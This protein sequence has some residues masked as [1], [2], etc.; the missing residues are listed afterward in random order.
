MQGL[1]DA[2]K[3]IND[4]MPDRRSAFVLETGASKSSGIKLAGET[5]EDWI[6]E[7]HRAS[8]TAKGQSKI[9]WATAVNLKIPAFDPNN[10]A[11][12][13]S[14]LYQRMYQDDPEQGYAYLED[15]MAKAEPSYGY[16]V[17]GRIMA[18]TRHRVVIT[19]NFDNLVADPSGFLV[20][21]IRWYADMNR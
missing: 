10:P 16:S 8:A 7:L 4:T 18:D 15:Q 20:P 17:L 21:A 19:V 2:F 1:I 5:V 6:G 9:N 3:R 13:Y 11:A 14:A 12:S